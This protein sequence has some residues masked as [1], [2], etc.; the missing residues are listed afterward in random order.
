MQLKVVDL[1]SRAIQPEEISRRK[2]VLSELYNKKDNVD[3]LLRS[4]WADEP[5]VVDK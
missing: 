1:Y 3:R 5:L 2:E 4:I